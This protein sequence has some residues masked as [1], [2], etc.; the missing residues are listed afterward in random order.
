MAQ[1]LVRDLDPK[2]VERLKKRAKADGR[3]LQAEVKMIL[4]Q[5]AGA[6]TVEMGKARQLVD[7]IRRRF[8][9][10]PFPDS[11]ELVREDRHR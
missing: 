2:A 1:I 10:R 8:H 9:G 3:S 7:E 11:T 6:P 5:A 4:E